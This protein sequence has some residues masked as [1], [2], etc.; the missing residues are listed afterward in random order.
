[1]LHFQ[2]PITPS[3]DNNTSSLA[4]AGMQAVSASFSLALP[5]TPG[6]NLSIRLLWTIDDH[7][8][9]HGLSGRGRHEFRHLD[10]SRARLVA[11]VKLV[12]KERRSG[13][14]SRRLW[15]MQ[16]HDSMK[17]F[18]LTAK[19]QTICLTRHAVGPSYDPGY[20][21]SF[22]ARREELFEE[23]KSGPAARARPTAAQ[24][25]RPL[26]HCCGKLYSMA[27]RKHKQ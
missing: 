20:C 21:Y 3:I 26:V 25:Q 4:R 18:I 22:S 27:C 24:V 11:F 16:T 2:N 17:M 19:A 8:E 10:A 6:P 9:P 14:R 15:S 12:V 23:A 5:A 7:L 1:M 13:S